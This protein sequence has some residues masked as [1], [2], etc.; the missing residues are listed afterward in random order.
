[1][2]GDGGETVIRDFLSSKLFPVEAARANVSVAGP[3]RPYGDPILRDPHVYGT[4]LLRLEAAGVIEFTPHKPL[5]SVD[6]FF[7]R[8]AWREAA[9]GD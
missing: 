1:M 4:F 2:W 7:G 6:W 5:E 3:A 8:E 9:F